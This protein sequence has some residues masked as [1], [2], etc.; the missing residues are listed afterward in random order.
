MKRRTLWISPVLLG[1]LVVTLASTTCSHVTA[2]HC[3]VDVTRDC[4]ILDPWPCSSNQ[5]ILFWEAPDGSWVPYPIPN[6]KTKIDCGA[7][8]FESTNET[9]IPYA[10]AVA[11]SEG[12]KQSIEVGGF[13]PCLFQRTCSCVGKLLL[14]P[15]GDNAGADPVYVDQL[16]ESWATGDDCEEEEED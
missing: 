11:P 5:C 6:A 15:C 8:E 1:L 10:S 3:Y 14:D 13:V 9:D 4:L 12:S 7:H 2:Q 16:L